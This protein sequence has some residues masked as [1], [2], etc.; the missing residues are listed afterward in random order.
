MDMAINS[1][2]DF[3]K[4]IFGRPYEVDGEEELIQKIYICLSARKGEFI[5]D[6]ELGGELYKIEIS[7][8]GAE[9]IL[10]A[11]AREAVKCV[12]GAEVQEI[13]IDGSMIY[14]LVYTDEGVHN[15]AVRRS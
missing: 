6:R 5:Y 3:D 11:Q 10:E 8:A 7:G 4:D 13:S 14:A 9:K 12:P 1:G 2:G 15:I